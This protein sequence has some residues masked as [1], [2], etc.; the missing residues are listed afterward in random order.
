MA[1]IIDIRSRRPNDP[2][3]QALVSPY[4]ADARSTAEIVLFPGIRYE[5]GE[6]TETALPAV[7]KSKAGRRAKRD[8][9]DIDG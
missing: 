9:L 1:T 5:Y 6:R 8:I 3:A 7:A 2:P 4:K